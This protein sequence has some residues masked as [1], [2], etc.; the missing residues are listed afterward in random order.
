MADSVVLRYFDGFFR[1]LGFARWVRDF[2]GDDFFGEETGFLSGGGAGVGCGAKGVLVGATDVVPL[3]YVFA[4]DAHGHYTISR[5]FH[6]GGFQFGP[7]IGGDGLGG[8]VSCHRFRAGAYAYVDAADGDGVGNCGDGLQGGG[9]GSVHGVEGCT[10]GVADVV[11]GHAGGFAA[12]E[13]G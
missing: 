12:T 6:G 5:F 9:A 10:G 13:L 8:V 11:E 3:C 2:Y 4:R 7:E 1:G